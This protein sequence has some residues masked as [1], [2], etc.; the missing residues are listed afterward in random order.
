[1]LGAL[2][3]PGKGRAVQ[4]AFIGLCAFAL[5]LCSMVNDGYYGFYHVPIDPIVF[6]LFEDDT[7]A[8]FTSLW[9]EHRIVLGPVV[10]L[11]LSVAQAL[12]A[13]RPARH[14]R[15]PRWKTAFAVLVPLLLFLVIR[16]RLGGFPLNAKDFSV[17]TEALLNASVPNGAIALSAAAGERLKAVDV[18][19]DPYAGLRA[20]GF[21]RPAQA[22]AAL[23]LA[24][25]DATDAE[26]AEALFT[27]SRVNSYA[28]A[29]P[30]HVVLVV[31][32]SWGYDL[33]RYQSEKNDLVGRLSPHLA[34]GLLFR[35]FVSSQNGTDGSL[36]ALLVNSPITPITGGP[37]GRLPFAQASVRPFR[38]AGYRTV[39][40]MG[41]SSNW[42]SI[43][44]SYPAQG[45]D[46]VRDVSDVLAAVPDAP[47]GT[48]GVP[49]G[50]LLQW[51]LGRIKEADAKGEHLFL[52]LMTATN[53]S[54]YAVPA[55]YQVR[56]LDP[57]VFAGRM[58]G[59]AAV[60]R[61][62]LES[63]Q[64]ACDAVG[65]LLDGLDAAGLSSRTIVA[66]TGDHNTRE[67]FQYPGT[68]DLPLRDRVPLLLA[69][70]KA[71]LG[72]RT[73]DLDRWAGHRDIFPTLAGLALSGA[74]I[75][76]SGED[77]LSPPARPPRALS[78][79][80]TLL[81]DAG[82]VPALERPA[83]ACWGPDGELS[84]QAADGCRPAVEP[85]AREEKAYRSLLDWTVRSQAL[86]A[87]H[88]G[89]TGPAA[90]P[91]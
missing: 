3:P 64:Y 66:A 47:V 30:P 53:H 11:L 83:V 20:D 46:E 82:V 7:G 28:A 24:P 1:L 5:A 2:W 25:A 77:L 88:L 16:G 55:G 72:G 38:A 12:L 67:F 13:T 19:R 58:L 8:V 31:M 36:E 32:E 18:G 15:G 76:R 10:A 79:F 84:A 69:V 68:R 60:G 37:L 41:W 29:H 22:A 62:Q 33:L 35:R 74:R 81:S 75:F 26:V 56:P 80:D 42:R 63:Y 54:P 23:G 90:A 51:A 71:Y 59:E 27:R 45:F 43:G 17:S 49:D 34:R 50:A 40:G 21:E 14:L 6:G 65:G 61:K 87:R 70:P 86:A 52:V 44:R 9:A 78:R 57:S 73:P 48:W 39:F 85:I 91:P 4:A 89:S